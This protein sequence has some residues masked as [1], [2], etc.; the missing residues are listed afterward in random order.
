MVL[1]EV[2]ELWGGGAQLDA[3]WS[4]VEE[5]GALCRDNHAVVGADMRVLQARANDAWGPLHARHKVEEYIHQLEA[6]AVLKDNYTAR[7]AELDAWM[8]AAAARFG[9]AVAFPNDL[10]PCEELLKQLHEYRCEER[11]RTERA[12]RAAADLDGVISHTLDFQGRPGFSPPPITA[13]ALSGA[14]DNLEGVVQRY[15]DRLHAEVA[16]QRGIVNAIQ[17]FNADAV[18]LLDWLKDKQDFLNSQYTTTPSTKSAA[19]S[20]KALMDAF[21]AEYSDRLEDLEALY[22]LGCKL[23]EQNCCKW[24][25]VYELFD[26]IVDGFAVAALDPGHTRHAPLPKPK[27]A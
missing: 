15:T 11:P 16:R 26:K 9:D 25:R 18:A 17:E 20:A 5:L 8:S 2:K 4:S 7:A 12:L 6:E 21:R 24:S 10:A 3:L 13:K 27:G 22:N 1:Q 19:R 23:M 14:W